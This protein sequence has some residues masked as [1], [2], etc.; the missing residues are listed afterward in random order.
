MAK[1][2]KRRL[3]NSTKP[4][5]FDAMLKRRGEAFY[6]RYRHPGPKFFLALNL[7]DLRLKKG[8]TQVQTAKKAQMAFNT[9]VNIEQAQPISN[10]TAD[11]L[12]RLAELFDTKMSELWKER[13]LDF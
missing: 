11:K 3:L 1:A 5:S 6:K 9:Y 12:I 13:K 10:P 2:Q 4:I 7:L 8:W